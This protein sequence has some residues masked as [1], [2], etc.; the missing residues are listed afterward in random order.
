MT[1]PDLPFPL[2]QS[3]EF[4]IGEIFGV[5]ANVD[6]DDICFESDDGFI[7]V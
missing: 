5:G 4:E 7:E 3:T 6:D 1:F 2:A